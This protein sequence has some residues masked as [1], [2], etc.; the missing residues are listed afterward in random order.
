MKYVK[1]FGLAVVAAMALM[2]FVGASAASAATLTSPAGTKL[3]VGAEIDASIEKGTTLLLTA[4]FAN[5]TCTESTVKG[6]ITNAGGAGV[7]V[8]GNIETLTFSNCP[9]WHVKVLKKGTLAIHGNGTLTSSGAEVTV[10]PLEGTSPTCT[11]VTNNTDIGTLT[12][13]TPATMHINASLTKT[14]SSGFL[15]ASP[16]KWEGSYVVTT[17]GTLIVDP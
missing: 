1:T 2:A 15:C 11:Y 3:G 10:S 12:S 5:V 14:A 7:P 4:G 13:G 6:K 8:S 16:A 9:G 17:P